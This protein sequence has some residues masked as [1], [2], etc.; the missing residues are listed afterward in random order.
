M[1]KPAHDTNS[2]DRNTIILPCDEEGVEGEN[3]N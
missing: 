2:R 1:N 3:D